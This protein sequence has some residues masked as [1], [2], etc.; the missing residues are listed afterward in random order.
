KSE[1]RII[2][3]KIKLAINIIIRDR[4]AVLGSCQHPSNKIL[5]SLLQIPR[6]I[7]FIKV[8]NPAV[9]V[10][11]KPVVVLSCWLFSPIPSIV[12]QGGG[13]GNLIIS[14]RYRESNI[15]LS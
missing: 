6:C 4:D 11:K 3:L 13:E 8:I 14:S 10:V 15:V 5:H 2:H 9:D 7:K 1:H 12:L